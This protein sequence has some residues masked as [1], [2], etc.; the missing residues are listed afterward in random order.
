MNRYACH[1]IVETVM[2]MY[3]AHAAVQ[4]YDWLIRFPVWLLTGS[5]KTG[6]GQP[7]FL[8]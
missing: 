7:P 3:Y 6:A 2:N 8:Q 4:K 1:D 5:L